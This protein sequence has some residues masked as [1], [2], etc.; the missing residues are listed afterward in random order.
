MILRSISITGWRCYTEPFRIGP[1]IEGLNILFAPNGRGKSTLFEALRR[2][3]LDGHRVSG[4]EVES[5][6]PWG[7]SLSPKV[8]VEFCHGGTEYRITKQFLENTESLLERKEKENFKRFAENNAADEFVR[9]LLTKTPPGHG[10]AR[11]E[12]WGFAQVLW[13]PQGN[14]SIGKLSGNLVT[15]INT[16]LGVQITGPGTGPIESRIEEL[17]LRYFAPKGKLKTGKDAPPLTGLKEKLQKVKEEYRSALETQQDYE[18]SSFR[19]EDLRVRRAQAKR[20]MNE[21]ARILK[22]TR[23]RAESYK[24]LYNE[25]KQRTEILKAAEAQ[26]NELKQRIDGIKAV[27]QEL[28]EARDIIIKLEMD[29][30]LLERELES[31]QKSVSDTRTALEDIRKERE[32]VDA[33][34]REAEQAEQY[35]NNK[36]KLNQLHKRINDIEKA[37]SS[38]SGYKKERSE[39]VAPDIKILKSIRKTLKD[40]DEAQV[41]L[42]AS[43]I[44]LEII[45]EKSG[46]VE[47]IAGEKIGQQKLFEGKPIELK[48]SPEVVANL[49]G[50][51]RLRASGPVGSVEEYR[52][53]INKAELKLNEL[54]DA[55]GTANL[56]ELEGLNEHAQ[57]LEQRIA[58]EETKLDTLLAGEIFE[59]IMQE[60]SRTELLLNKVIESHPDWEKNLPDIES[61]SNNST[62]LHDSFV[63]RVENAE[64]SWIAAQSALGAVSDRKTN[65]TTRLEET[66]T[67]AKKLE[68][69]ISDLTSDGKKDS[70]REDDLKK[71]ILSYDAAKF[72]LENVEQKLL[73]FG[74]NPITIVD[75][76]ERQ[77]SAANESVT[78]AI[79]E[80]KNA[81][82]KL[83]H[84]AAQGVY[85]VLAQVEEEITQLEREVASEELRVKAIQLLHETFV[86]C[87]AEAVSSVAAPVEI[88]ATRIFHRIAG[89]RLGNLKI[90]QGFD[91]EYVIP[92]IVGTSITLDNVSGGEQEQIFLATRLALAD[93]LAKEE[94]QLVVLDDVLTVTDTGRLARV[95]NVLEEETQRLQI[96][97]LTCHPE[98]YRGLDAACFFDL[99]ALLE[100]GNINQIIK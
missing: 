28:R 34:R 6:R 47:V 74:D 18:K 2:A 67:R 81:E 83:E 35:I 5:L 11:P 36:K 76:L 26:Y 66:R 44:T 29:I 33:A 95:L 8:A 93:V 98:R 90:G 39:L 94:R 41:R 59:D 32:L 14:I 25:K 99:E 73:E 12:N 49:P 72:S 3:L 51:A 86:T 60:K 30:P 16:L 62:K 52:Q 88:T 68:T 22:K 57:K 4:K 91:P 70:E 27:R 7:R 100:N 50:I 10:L 23:D 21:I 77:L 97:I 40:R 69:K 78:K 61:L 15:D 37:Q 89:R 87:R 19:V 31:R 17:Y 38:I 20:D 43:L 42:D 71:I 9:A 46:T 92:E 54:A 45:P 82:G 96:L 55:Y 65:Y 63:E 80:E 64:K 48:G 13:A 75:K 58:E 1:F 79:E 56:E 84:L 24:T 85:S 53:Q